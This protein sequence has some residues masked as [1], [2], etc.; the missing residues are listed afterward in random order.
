[1]NL[2]SIRFRLGAWY[3][4]LLAVLLVSFSIF[5][6]LTLERILERNLHDTLAKEAQTIGDALL[7]KIDETGD[8]YV[9]N[10]IEEHFAP[11]TTNHFL[12]V[13]RENGA[14]TYQSGQPRDGSFDPAR[15]PPAK[16]DEPT[17][18]HEDTMPNGNKLFVYSMTYINSEGVKFEIQAGASNNPIRDVLQSLLTTLVIALP[19]IVIAAVAGGYVLTRSALQPLGQIATIAETITSRNLNERV[20]ESG[21]G[22]EIEQLTNSL[23][24]MMARLEE[25]FQQIHRFSADASHE[26]RTPLAIL[27]GELEELLREPHLT[28]ELRESV[29]SALEEAERLSRIVEQL[30]EMTR[31]E[32]GEKLS[33]LTRFDL[34]ELILTAVDQLRP[35]ADEKNLHLRFEGTQSVDVR[36]DPLRLRQVVV[37]LVDNAIKYTTPGGSISVTTAATGNRAILEVRD[38]GIGIPENAIPHVFERFYR[39]GGDRSRQLG[40]TGLGLAIVKSICTAFGGD[41]SVYSELGSGTTFRVELPR[42]S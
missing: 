37:N 29:S 1:V 33:H 31:L 4:G 11:R 41:V 6:Y 26:I 12:R 9:I 34:T 13:L 28:A 30:L 40:G 2:R 10:E 8:P 35:L 16:L 19:L 22:D 20:P 38:T 23:N 24:R 36:G 32:T 42:E 39:V 3:V 5:I 21:T 18:W 17:S 15:V 27:R 14:V 25:S 7:S